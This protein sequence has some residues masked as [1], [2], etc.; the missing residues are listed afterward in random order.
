MKVKKSI[1]KGVENFNVYI[2]D[3]GYTLEYT[4]YDAEDEWVTVK[5]IVS[6]V[7]ELCNIIKEIDKIP[8]R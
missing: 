3:N 1:V 5:V 7:D 6:S 8:P 2:F 4:G